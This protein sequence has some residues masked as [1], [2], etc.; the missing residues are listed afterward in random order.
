[1][2]GEGFVSEQARSK[3]FLLANVRPTFCEDRSCLRSF[4]Y[5][6]C[7]RSLCALHDLEFNRIT[8][9]KTLISVAGDRAVMHEYV[10]P[11]VASDKSV[12][13]RI[14]KPLHSTFQTVHVLLLGEVCSTVHN[15]Y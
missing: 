13:F 12:S 6:R 4:A 8:F 11:I 10:G 7:L 1:M 5:V 15:P 9:L 3:N 14:V 2:E